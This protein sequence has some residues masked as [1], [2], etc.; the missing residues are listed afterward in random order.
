MV[1]VIEFLC[2]YSQQYDYRNIVLYSL[3]WFL[4]FIWNKYVIVALTH[5]NSAPCLL[6]DGVPTPLTCTLIAPLHFMGEHIC[7]SFRLKHVVNQ[8]LV[9]VKAATLL[10]QV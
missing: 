4:T 6:L 7:P 2:V 1:V 8:L 3:V 9:L 5:L 10:G